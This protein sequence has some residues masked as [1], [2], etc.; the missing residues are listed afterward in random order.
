MHYRKIAKV[1]KSVPQLKNI[2]TIYL[3]KYTYYEYEVRFY[4]TRRL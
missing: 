4:N 1:L 2:K 3:V